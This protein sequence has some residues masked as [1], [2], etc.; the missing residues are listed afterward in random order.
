MI[1]KDVYEVYQAVAHL[2]VNRDYKP[3]EFELFGKVSKY[4]G[5]AMK[6]Y[7]DSIKGDDIGSGDVSQ[8]PQNP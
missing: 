1:N 2:I 3:G 4:I 5:G 6:E 7:E 8:D